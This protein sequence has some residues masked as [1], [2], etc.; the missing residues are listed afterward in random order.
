M[1]VETKRISLLM[2][3]ILYFACKRDRKLLDFGLKSWHEHFGEEASKRVVVAVDESESADFEDLKGCQIITT[4]FPRGYSLNQSKDCVAGMIQ[5][6]VELDLAPCERV[7]K[8]DCDTLPHNL[9]L[10]VNLRLHNELV[11]QKGVVDYRSAQRIIA[12]YDYA[13][14]YAYQLSGRAINL[15][16]QSSEGLLEAADAFSNRTLSNE[17]LV[18]WPED[19]TIS[20]IVKMLLPDPNDWALF[21]DGPVNFVSDY[22]H[23]TKQKPSNSVFINYGNAQGTKEETRG[24]ILTAMQS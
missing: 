15:I 18:S 8:I 21:P 16:K 9:D 2:D 10:L 23:V 7:L 11:G 3:K 17:T 5:T 19:Q 22:N 1:H 20:Q 14:G 6:F 24:R 4:S 12:E 13:K